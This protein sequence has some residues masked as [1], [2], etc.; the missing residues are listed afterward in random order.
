MNMRHG[1][2]RQID[3]LNGTQYEGMWQHD[4]KCGSGKQTNH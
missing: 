4:M 2:G 1:H 3:H